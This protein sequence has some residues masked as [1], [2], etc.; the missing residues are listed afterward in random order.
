MPATDPTQAWNSI[1]ELD[2]LYLFTHLQY[3]EIVSSLIRAKLSPLLRY[4]EVLYGPVPQFDSGTPIDPWMSQTKLLGDIP[5]RYGRLNA[6]N[7]RYRRTTSE[8]ISTSHVWKLLKQLELT[9]EPNLNKATIWV[10]VP[11]NAAHRFW[12]SG[13][14]SWEVDEEPYQFEVTRFGSSPEDANWSAT[15]F[16][17]EI[18]RCTRAGSVPTP[19]PNPPAEHDCAALRL[20]R[21]LH[22][23]WQ[24]GSKS[25][26]D[27]ESVETE[28]WIKAKLKLD[29]MIEDFPEF[30]SLLKYYKV[31]SQIIM[32]I[33]NISLRCRHFLCCVWERLMRHS[34]YLAKLRNPYPMQNLSATDISLKNLLRGPFL[35]TN[36]SFNWK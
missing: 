17:I 11:K 35:V 12:K 26:N 28:F 2:P 27:F 31:L 8:N 24:D 30:D 19:L 29:S 25:F 6:P 1:A 18:I 3:M 4:L 34:N 14:Y 5:I 22:Q 20:G 23:F 9:K 36:S 33:V 7:F 15:R 10:Q 21:Q 16:A 13:S 32:H